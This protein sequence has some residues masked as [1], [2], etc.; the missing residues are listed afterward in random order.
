LLIYPAIYSIWRR[1][2][3]PKETRDDINLSKPAASSGEPE[4]VEAGRRRKFLRP[5]L[6]LVLVAT[7]AGAAY[8]AWTKFG[9]AR[10]T[11]GTPGSVFATQTVNGLTVKFIHPKGELQKGM[12]EILIEFHDVA[13]GEM[14]DVGTLK[15]ELDMNMAG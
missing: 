13:S 2:N 10:S 11:S 14:V 1:H 8:I 3:L 15:F 9:Q 5:L 4:K 6:L 7:A 12:N